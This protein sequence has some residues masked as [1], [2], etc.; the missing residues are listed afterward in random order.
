MLAC[1]CPPLQCYAKMLTD[2]ARRPHEG[3]FDAEAALRHVEAGVFPNV[4]TTP[5]PG[6]DIT[7]MHGS[8]RALGG[9]FCRRCGTRGIVQL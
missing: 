7:F 2:N 1:L 8:E 5:A 3:V 6:P 4:V 9:C